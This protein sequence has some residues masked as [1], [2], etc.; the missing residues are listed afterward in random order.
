M[1]RGIGPTYARALVQ[2][3]GEA[4]FDLVEQQPDQLRE[5]IGTKRAARIVAGWADQKAIRE[6]TLFLRAHGVGTSRAVQIFKTYGQEA[7]AL[8][9]ENPYRL[10]RDIRGIGFRT[11]DQ[12]AAKPGIEKEAIIRLRAGL[13][14]WL[15]EATG[16]G[17]CG[18]PVAELIK[19]TAALIEVRAELF[20]EALGLELRDGELIADTVAGAP[21][22]S[23]RALPLR[24][25]HRRPPPSAILRPPFLARHRP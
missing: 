4:V 16:N 20:E 7:I 8:I 5:V 11:A 14:F 15:S 24:A 2:A 1:I 12:V 13:S 21:C 19:S 3:F 10:A 9:T 25:G 17:H 6:I 22:L 23:G 18:L